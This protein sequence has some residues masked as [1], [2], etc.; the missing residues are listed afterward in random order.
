MKKCILM[1][2]VALIT[3]CFANNVQAGCYEKEIYNADINCFDSWNPGKPQLRRWM[4][5]KLQ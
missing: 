4:H 2:G 5:L 1:T 3:F